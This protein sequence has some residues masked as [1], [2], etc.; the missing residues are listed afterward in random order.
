LQ[1]RQE[2]IDREFRRV[3]QI[4]EETKL[5]DVLRIRRENIETLGEGEKETIVEN[6]NEKLIKEFNLKIDSMT[7]EELEDTLILKEMFNND[8]DSDNDEITKENIENQ[9]EG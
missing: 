6:I 2:E 4:N 5:K 8:S 9:I 1:K 3:N 7:R